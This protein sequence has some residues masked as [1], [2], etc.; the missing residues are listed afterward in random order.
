MKK[1]P[2]TQGVGKA[3]GL[4]A[5]PGL[6]SPSDESRPAAVCRD[7]QLRINHIRGEG[8]DTEPARELYLHSYV[9]RLPSCYSSRL[10]C[11]QK[12]RA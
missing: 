6:R 11:D 9:Q 2:H 12:V 3:V 10:R 4:K 8:A 7:C 5:C 1:A